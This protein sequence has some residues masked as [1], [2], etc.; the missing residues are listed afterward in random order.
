MRNKRFFPV[1]KQLVDGGSVTACGAIFV[2]GVPQHKRHVN[3]T[4][5]RFVWQEKE[6]QQ[7][8][9]SFDKIK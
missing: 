2:S 5:E 1:Q 9:F 8:W 3:C 6:I 4:F 7:Q